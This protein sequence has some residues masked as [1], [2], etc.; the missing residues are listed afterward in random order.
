MKSGT[1]KRIPRG[2]P[3][4]SKSADPTVAAAFG[5]AVVSLRLSAE[6]SQESLALSAGIGR[7]NM[8][9]IENGRTV[10]N[11]VGVVKIAAALGCSLATLVKEFEKA[12]KLASNG[13]D[14]TAR[15]GDV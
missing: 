5:Q 7:S 3:L 2:R 12:Y 15:S 11:F 9:A 1:G 14:R 10:P 6:M 4:G 13:A 8:S